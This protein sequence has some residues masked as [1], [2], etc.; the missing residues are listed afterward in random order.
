M[1]RYVLL[2]NIITCITIGFSN[3]VFAEDLEMINRPVNISGLTGLLFTTSP[4]TIPQKSIEFGLGALSEQSTVPDYSI[5][6]IPSISITAGIG[7]KGELAL[8]GSYFRKTTDDGNNRVRGAGD[9][10]LAYKWN[11]LPQTESSLLPALALII[12]GIAPTSD[13]ETGLGGVMHWGAKLGLSAGREMIWGDHVIG[14]FADGNIAVQDLSDERIRDKY[15]IV[16]GGLLFPI[17]KYKNLQVLL[18]YTIVSGLERITVQGGDYSAMTY[19]LRLVSER[20][21]LTIGTQFVHKQA[22]GFDNS[23]RITGMMSIKMM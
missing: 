14:I 17:S 8:K 19:G 15:S 6:E 21:N 13:K 22:E 2:L 10:Q 11:F 7:E 16:N 20:F 12:A 9:T 23:S 18:E 5:N 3:S 4:F 1:R